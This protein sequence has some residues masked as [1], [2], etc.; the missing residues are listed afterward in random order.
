M[1]LT[2]GN[3]WCSFTAVNCAPRSLVVLYAR[4]IKT[5]IS[6]SLIMRLWRFLMEIYVYHSLLKRQ[7]KV[8]CQNNHTQSSL[9]LKKRISGAPAVWARSSHF[10]MV[11]IKGRDW[12][13]CH[14]RWMHQPRHIYVHVKKQR[15][16]HIVT[17]AT[18]LSMNNL[19]HLPK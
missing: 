7:R 5:A 1:A 17:E 18:I 4:T 13:L 8:T 6:Y 16:R 10:V 15:R 12:S 2:R 19:Y 11:L 14:F 3:M 9:K